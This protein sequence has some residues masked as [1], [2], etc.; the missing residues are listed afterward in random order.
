MADQPAAD[1]E[2]HDDLG[3]VEQ[4]VKPPDDVDERTALEELLGGRRGIFDT[5]LPAI[6]FV[7][8]N[9]IVGLRAGIYAALSLAGLLLVLRLLRREALR[10]AFGGFAAVA[11]AAGFAAYTGSARDYFL[12]GILINIGYGAVF[13]ISALV[14]APLLGVVLARLEGHGPEWRQDARVR[15]LFMLATWLWAGI[16]F[17]RA[18]VQGSLY[19]ADRPGWLA[20]ARLATGWPLFLASLPPTIALIR[21]ARPDQAP[22][23]ATL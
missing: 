7:F 19:L 22:E 13:A 10:Y 8:V 16:F 12:P 17:L 3:T 20:A 4:V 5:A 6:L 9:T 18:A 21:K 14:G 23:T 2:R 11:I 1:S 15:R